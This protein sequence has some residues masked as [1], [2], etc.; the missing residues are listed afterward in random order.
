VSKVTAAMHTPKNEHVLRF[1]AVHN[2]VFAYGQA[3][4][5]DSKIVLAGTA[6]IREAGKQKRNDL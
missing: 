2:N 6:D 1:D 5:A 3:A 4:A